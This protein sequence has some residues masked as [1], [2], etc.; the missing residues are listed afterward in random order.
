MSTTEIREL[1]LKLPPEQRASLARDLLSSLEGAAE[2]FEPE[3]AEEAE[4]RA[5]AYAAGQIGADDW[6]ASLARARAR[7]EQ[8][9]SP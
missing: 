4:A 8:R 5:E 7:L 6:E 3:W 9:R 1:A 2:N